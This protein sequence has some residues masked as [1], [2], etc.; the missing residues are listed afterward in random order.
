[1]MYAAIHR[2]RAHNTC[3]VRGK[4]HQRMSHVDSKISMA[5]QTL[6]MNVNK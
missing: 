4:D 3:K 6:D 2:P 5:H 1:M